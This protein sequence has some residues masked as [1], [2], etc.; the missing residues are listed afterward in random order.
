MNISL[1]ASDFSQLADFWRRAPDI[2]RTVLMRAMT[3]I[4]AE[5]VGDL[6]QG[7]PKGAGGSAGLQGSIASEEEALADNVIGLVYTDKPHAQYVELGT[8]P[9]PVNAAGIQALADWVQAKFVEHDPDEALGIAHA[10]AWKIRRQGTPANP[11]WQRTWD[12][13]QPRIRAVFDAA[14]R[15]I[16]GELAGGTA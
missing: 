10:I 8:R 2:T 11:V 15:R 7:L 5:L 6:T 9:H 13:K 4:D 16:A 3:A 1:D 14:M 12:A